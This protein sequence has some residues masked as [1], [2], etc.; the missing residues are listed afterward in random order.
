MQTDLQKQRACIYALCDTG[1]EIPKLVPQREQTRIRSF[2]PHTVAQQGGKE[3]VAGSA[4]FQ[5]NKYQGPL[6]AVC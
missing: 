1:H 2:L 5:K 3:K 6:S 4:F